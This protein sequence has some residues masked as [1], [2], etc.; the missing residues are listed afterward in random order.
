M[1]L[2][3]MCFCC[4]LA[5]ATAP[6]GGRSGVPVAMPHPS[7]TGCVE[8]GELS[9]FV[10]ALDAHRQSAQRAAL[11]GLGAER[12][13]RRGAFGAVE[14]APAL[15]S[16]LDTGGR[17][18]A[19]VA[20]YASHFEPVVTLAKTGRQLHRIDERPRA[21][22]VPVLVCG[23]EHCP[24]PAAPASAPEPVLPVL[25]ELAPGEELGAA[26]GVAYDY[27]WADVSY[28]RVERCGSGTGR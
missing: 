10:E 25:V 21:H 4:A 24:R 17:R 7:V 28:D 13:E 3:A 23:V 18:L 8:S 26:L 1:S 9:H 15:D 6:V 5:C 20:K 22:A 12:E 11:A 2:A 27:W 16:T 14:A 19:V